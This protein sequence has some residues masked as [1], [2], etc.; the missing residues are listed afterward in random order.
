[1]VGER[2]NVAGSKIF[3]NLIEEKNYVKA[4]EIA[5]SQIKNGANIIDINMDD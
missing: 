5:R 2:N 1:M 3:K 4:L